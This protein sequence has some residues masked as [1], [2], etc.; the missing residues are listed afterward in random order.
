MEK[1]CFKCRETKPISEFYRHPM[2]GD[3]H[4]GKCKTCAKR[5]V[6]ERAGRLGNN[7]VWL[8]YERRRCRAKQARYRQLGLAAKSKP[9]TARKWYARNAH[10][11]KAELKAHRAHKRGLLKQ[12]ARC[13]HCG[14]K[15]QELEKHHYDYS[16]PLDVLWLCV[17]CHGKT[18][19]KSN[20]ELTNEG[21]F[22]RRNPIQR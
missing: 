16:K 21:H 20:P 22:H 5:D 17:P 18:R 4:L 8:A 14:L 3:G 9:E 11:K 6:A 19:W 10:K 1:Q 2:M 13:E 12:P 7:P 15:T